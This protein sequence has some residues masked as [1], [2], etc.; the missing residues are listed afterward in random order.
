MR[1]TDRLFT[2]LRLAAFAAVIGVGCICIG[3]PDVSWLWIFAPLAVF[4]LLLRLH[5]PVIRKLRRAEAS[6]QYYIDSLARLA[7]LWKNAASDGT[8][9][10]DTQHLWS[11]DLDIFG[12]G[13]LFQKL[14]QCRTLPAKRKLAGWLTEVPSADVISERQLQAE[15]LREHLD[16]RERLAAIETDVDWASAEKTLQI[17]LTQPA[18]KFP[19]WTLWAARV[20]GAASIVVVSLAMA[21]VVS[22]T[23]IL[24]MLMLQGPFV[25]INR[26]RIKSV[27][28]EVDDVDK[29][30]RQLAEVT[31]QFET[32]P[33][34]EKSLQQL[35]NRLTADGIIASERI[36]QL[37]RLV[38][39]LN[40]ALRNQ[41][42][43]PVA[44][45]LGLFIHLPHRIA[46]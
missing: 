28:D 12:T 44:W 34:N 7:G 10:I 20:V 14:N 4:V 23:Y 9:F 11:S 21:G 45:A 3:D 13:S 2:R 43:I 15:S 35:Q 46:R 36:Q 32:Y 33:L 27:M 1:S 16:L 37:S 19:K 6:Q 41:F 5:A 39:W 26:H 38:Q 24:L 42:F 17:W 8:Q 22:I 18:G 25:V 29:A 40:N 30:L 31:Q